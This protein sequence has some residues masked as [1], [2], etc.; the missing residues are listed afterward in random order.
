[1]APHVSAMDF[2]TALRKAGACQKALRVLQADAA[3][4]CSTSWWR[5]HVDAHGAKGGV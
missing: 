2:G 1:M 4:E 5:R 3:S